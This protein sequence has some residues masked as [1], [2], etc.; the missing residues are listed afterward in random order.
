MATSA[1]LPARR[2][3]LPAGRAAARRSPARPA[4][5]APRADATATAESSV[6]KPSSTKPLKVI[7]AGGGIGGLTF[8]LAAQERGIDVELFERVKVYK[9]FGGPIQM[10]C[11]A[12]GALEAISKP[13][14]E[15]VIS[16]GCVTGDRIN[17][18]LD[19]VSGKWWMRFD[20]RQPCRRNG[21]PLTL[22]INRPDLLQMLLDALK[23]GTV[24]RGVEV[25]GYEQDE[26]G[27]TALLSD[28]RKVRGDVLVASDGIRSKCRKQFKG[29]EDLKKNVTYSGYTVYTC[30]P[31]F[32]PADVDK[33]GYQVFLGGCTLND[34]NADCY[35]VASDVGDGRSQYYA[36]HREPEGG[37][38]D[39]PM[40][41]RL[42]EIFQGWSEPVLD[43]IRASDES[44]IERRDIFDR[45]PTLT[46]T[47]QRMC[48]LGDAAHAVQPNM[49][50]G[51]CQAIEDAY[52]L[53]DELCGL[54]LRGQEAVEGA[55]VRYARRR[56]LRAGNVHGFS[57]L[58][59]LANDLY[60]PFLGSDPYSVYPEP[61]RVLLRQVEKL[62]VPH[63]G[64]VIGQ[65]G[66]MFVMDGIL[67]YIGAGNVLGVPLPPWLGG[68][69]QP[70]PDERVPYCQVP[71]VADNV[72]K[73]DLTDEDFVM[74]G[75]P[76]LAEEHLQAGAAAPTGAA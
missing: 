60:R 56:V 66:M 33:I 54:E 14:A 20:T 1:A 37:V 15:K 26:E 12:L 51:G 9:P 4:R 55:L 27:I 8:A 31:E 44:E 47:D 29:E 5:A 50:Q 76:G 39:K 67:E 34:V 65:V 3:R 52:A 24:E 23:P 71:G 42:L 21:L 13:F 22:V 30:C 18:L 68:R 70:K 63:P 45:R 7:V 35:F 17:G 46:W 59:P 49:G 25:M 6:V 48:L 40:K 74:K 38:D 36:F 19:G 73:R 2:C 58:A 16:F 41:E 72:A 75:I 43:R 28:G 61:V 62:R 57:R 32:E 10:Q 53:A 69:I 64:R 11:N